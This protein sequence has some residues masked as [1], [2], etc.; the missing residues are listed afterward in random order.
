MQI[1]NALALTK[2]FMAKLIVIS[3][4]K[5]RRSKNICRMAKNGDVR[6]FWVIDI[7]DF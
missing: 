7:G 6:Y 2:Q 4:N 3:L 5:K 1:I